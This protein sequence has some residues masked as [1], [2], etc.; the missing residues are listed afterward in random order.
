MSFRI[1][2]ISNKYRWCVGVQY[3]ALIHLFKIWTSCSAANWCNAESVPWAPVLCLFLR[4]R[5]PF[6]TMKTI[7]L[8]RPRCF[9]RP[10][11]SR[12]NTA[13]TARTS[14]SLAISPTTG[15][16]HRGEEQHLSECLFFIF[17]PS[18]ALFLSCFICWFFF[19]FKGYWL[20]YHHWHLYKFFFKWDSNEFETRFKTTL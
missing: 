10:T 20:V 19:F 6:W 15:F 18:Q 3:L 1:K 12:P 16:Y 8:L 17:S 14:T 2:C 13:T 7:V 9:W 11:R 5:S 4:W